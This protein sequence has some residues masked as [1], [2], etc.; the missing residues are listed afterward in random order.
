MGGNTSFG[1]LRRDGIAIRRYF[2]LAVG[3][4]SLF[5]GTH[6]DGR[7]ELQNMAVNRESTGNVL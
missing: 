2:V 4:F 6:F 1:G 3:D 5:G 7:R